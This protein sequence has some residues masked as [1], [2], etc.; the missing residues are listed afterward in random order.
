MNI[1]ELVKRASPSPLTSKR[2]GTAPLVFFGLVD[3]NEYD[4]ADITLTG[5]KGEADMLLLAHCRNNFMKILGALKSWVFCE[6]PVAGKPCG[7]CM[8]CKLIAEMEEVN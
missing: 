4:V 1:H 7:V 3:S 5:D 2:I 8:V 6:Y